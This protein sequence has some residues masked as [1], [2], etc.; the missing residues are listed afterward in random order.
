MAADVAAHV[1]RAELALNELHGGKNRP[2][3]TAGAKRRRPPM[4]LAGDGPLRLGQAIGWRWQDDGWAAIREQIGPTRGDEFPQAL[5]HHAAGIFASH[6]QHALSLDA[7]CDVGAAQDRVHRLLDEFRLA[8]FDD[9][10]R[11]L[12]RAE[13]DELG[14]DQRVGDIEHVER[15]AA[16]AEHVGKDKGIEACTESVKNKLSQTSKFGLFTK[17]SN[18]NWPNPTITKRPPPVNGGRATICQV[19]PRSSLRSTATHPG[20]AC[21]QLAVAA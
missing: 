2:F 10:N 13:A 21:G 11:F 9:E 5:L 15:H 3:G 16:F 14:L 7:S 8:L 19:T 17:N 4:H 18:G 1:M 12:I 6:R 20:A